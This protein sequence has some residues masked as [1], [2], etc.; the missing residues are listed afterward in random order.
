[1]GSP[2]DDVAVAKRFHTAAKRI[3]QSGR[4][5][6]VKRLAIV[7]LNERAQAEGVGHVLPHAVASWRGVAPMD[8]TTSWKK[9]VNEINRIAARDRLRLLAITLRVE[10]DHEQAADLE[11]GIALADAHEVMAHA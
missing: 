1:M 9:I 8:L 5:D 7:Q 11:L 10:G 6:A 3:I 2:A 4:S